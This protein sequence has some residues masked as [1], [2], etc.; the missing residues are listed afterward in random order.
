MGGLAITITGFTGTGKT[1]FCKQHALRGNCLVFD[2]NNE[3]DLPEIDETKPF[4]GGQFRYTGMDFKEFLNIIEQ[5]G[6]RKVNN[7]NIVLEDC[8]GFMKGQIGAR[9]LQIFQAK[10]HTNNNY[11]FIYHAVELVPKDIYRFSNMFV[12][13]PTNESVQQ[14]SKRFPILE[15]PAIELK[16]L[17]QKYPNGFHKKIIKLQ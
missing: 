13:F 17:K 11:F 15:R 16:Q 2:I 14:I 4:T 10:R 1:Y 9:A 6:V 5:N 8:S 12:L 3:Y 7:C